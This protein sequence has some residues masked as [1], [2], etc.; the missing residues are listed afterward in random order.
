ME[1]NNKFNNAIN[2][3]TQGRMTPW[4]KVDLTPENILFLTPLEIGRRGHFYLGQKGQRNFGLR[5]QISLAQGV[6]RPWVF[7][8]MKYALTLRINSM[9]A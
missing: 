4:A 6:I 3:K 5:G 2:W 9:R 7:Q 1:T 8:S